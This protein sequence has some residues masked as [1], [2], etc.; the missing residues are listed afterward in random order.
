MADF[1]FSKPFRTHRLFLA[2]FLGGVAVFTRLSFAFAVLPIFLVLASLVPVPAS[3]SRSVRFKKLLLPFCAGAAMSSAAAVYYFF[4]APRSFIFDTLEYFFI[5]GA[6]HWRPGWQAAISLKEK[7]LLGVTILKSP[8]YRASL[9]LFL[10]FCILAV[11]IYRYPFWRKTP[12]I[13]SFSLAAAMSIAAFAV[14]PAWIQYFAAPLPFI[15]MSVAFVVSGSI[16]AAKREPRKKMILY[17]GAGLF[18]LS[19]V[20]STIQNK[21]IPEKIKFAFSKKEWIPAR[22]YTISGNVSEITG[23]DKFILTLAPIFAL[24]GGER[25]YPELSTGPF[26]FRYGRFFSDYQHRIAV[27]TDPRSLPALL[28]QE[29]PDAVLVGFENIFLEE[30]LIDYAERSGWQKR[31]VQG[32]ILYTPANHN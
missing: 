5:T 31:E 9:L 13:L 32:F 3:A 18:I 12:F 29:P 7:L 8:P 11:T 27:S 25:I 19:A 10:F 23:P 2:G 28:Q 17:L 1:D 14:T 24:E 15:L 16:T 30:S 22:V 26:L 21:D 4:K 6:Q 20:I